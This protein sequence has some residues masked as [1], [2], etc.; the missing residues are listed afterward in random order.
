MVQ[1]T[2]KSLTGNDDD[3]LNLYTPSEFVTK[4]CVIQGKGSSVIPFAPPSS[5]S[6]HCKN[7]EGFR[8]LGPLIIFLLSNGVPTA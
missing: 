1:K 2:T 3:I 7:N 5:Y 4:T 8:A 6:L